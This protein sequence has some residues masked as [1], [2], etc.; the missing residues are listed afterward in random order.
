[1]FKEL[2]KS[3]EKDKIIHDAQKKHFPPL[4]LLGPNYSRVTKLFD[5]G[6]KQ[7]EIWRRL[8]I[9]YVDGNRDQS[10]RSMVLNILNYKTLVSNQ[11]SLFQT[12]TRKID[13]STQN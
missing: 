6:P 7:I 12:I 3:D 5:S 2:S 11:K 4:C 1:L 13:N 8:E 9:P 10:N